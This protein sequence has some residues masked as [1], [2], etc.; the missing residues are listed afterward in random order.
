M[1]SVRNA[2]WLAMLF[3]FIFAFGFLFYI[4][5]QITEKIYYATNTAQP[6]ENLDKHFLSWLTFKAVIIQGFYVLCSIMVFFTFISS[7][8]NSMSLRDYL[9]SS[10]A[11]LLVTPVVIFV[12]ASFWNTFI[13]MGITFD[14]I[15]TTFISSFSQIMLVNFICGL[16]AFVFM[17]KGAKIE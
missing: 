9:Y 6:S 14:E 3:A 16:L 1:N 12:I 8:F 5:P 11:G 15:S 10:I 7:I 2:A 17:R 4:V 13:L